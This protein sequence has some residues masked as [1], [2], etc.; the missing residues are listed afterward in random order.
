MVTF[1]WSAQT[2]Q[3]YILWS[4]NAKGIRFE[5]FQENKKKNKV[6]HDLKQVVGLWR[7]VQIKSYSWCSRR[8]PFRSQSN[9][10]APQ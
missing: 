5:Y 2:Q 9:I 10:I 1:F 7:G 3:E 6:A 4:K 8:Q